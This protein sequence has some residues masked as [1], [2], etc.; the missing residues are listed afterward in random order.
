LIRWP[1]VVAVFV[2]DNAAQTLVI[3]YARKDNTDVIEDTQPRPS[4]PDS[5]T[6]PKFPALKLRKLEIWYEL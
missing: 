4:D 2:D 3:Y 6:N 5:F 1:F